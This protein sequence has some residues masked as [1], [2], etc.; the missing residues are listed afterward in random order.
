MFTLCSAIWVFVHYSISVPAMAC[1]TDIWMPNYVLYLSFLVPYDRQV[2]IRL[3]CAAGIYTCAIL[4]SLQV[5]Y[6][7]AV[8]MERSVMPHV[9]HARPVHTSNHF[10][11]RGTA[12]ISCYAHHM[13]TGT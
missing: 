6:A 10:K 4:R 12:C 13:C 11:W 2:P 5:L 3:C 7:M 8:F 9:D 1:N